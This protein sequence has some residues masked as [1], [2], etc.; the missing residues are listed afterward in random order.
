MMATD[1][2]ALEKEAKAR[3]EDAKKQKSYFDQDLREGYFF[4]APLRCRDITSG[5][6]NKARPND[7]AELQI[8]LGMEVAQDFATE[9]M[10]AFTPENSNWAR[11]KPSIDVDEVDVAELE[12]QAN[13]QTEKI[14]AA[15]KASSFYAATGKAYMPDMGL[16]TT[17]MVIDVTRP[18]KPFL[19]HPVP[20]REMEINTG[21]DG[22]VDDRFIVRQTKYRHLPALLSGCDLPPDVEKKIKEQGNKECKVTWGWWRLWAKIDDV[23]WQSVVLLG[24]KLI[25][26][27]V[28]QGEGSCPFLV[29]R[30]N[31]DPMFAFGIGP[32]LQSLPE[33]RRL[34]EGEALKIENFDFQVHPA[35]I[36]PDDGV[37]NFSN[38]I[39]PGMG[40]AARPWGQGKV[41]ET[42]SFEG[43]INFAALEIQRIES[44][45]R[46]LHF[47]DQPEQIGKAPPTAEQWADERNRSKRRIGTPGKSFFREGPG[48]VFL[49]FKYLLE[50]LGKIDPIEYQGS[51]ITLVP[52]DPTEQAQ[53]FQEVQ[54]AIQILQ[55]NQQNFSQTG[56]VQVDG[57]ATMKNIK[58]KYGDKIV[59][60]RDQKGME[61]AAG[62]LSGIMGGGGNGGPG[63]PSDLGGL[64]V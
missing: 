48:E 10:N 52:Y 43:N 62:M 22:N 40:Y 4:T 24:E 55:I 42:L 26:D 35:F 11:Q 56:E 50:K 45:I 32:T 13:A 12:E 9:L 1:A 59:V 7:A 31:A 58:D 37:L 3:L 30:F 47:V 17:G 33:F 18:D 23:Y 60:F 53:E 14:M 36:Y 28:L 44:R 41:V 20:I 15:I 49:R 25:H 57:P 16:G 46:K 63:L 8:S 29:W 64:P 5:S 38:G 19:C 21:P 27:V 6:T 39:E 2:K 51:A 34:D 54:T 61:Q